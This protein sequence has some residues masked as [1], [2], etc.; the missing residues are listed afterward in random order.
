MVSS[1]R[2]APV[3]AD[4]YCEETDSCAGPSGDDQ[5]F[6]SDNSRYLQSGTGY[7][8]YP[9]SLGGCPGSQ[10]QEIDPVSVVFWGFATAARSLNHIEA[11]TRWTKRPTPKQNFESWGDCG[12]TYGERASG[13]YSR[14]HVRVRK[15]A[16]EYGSWGIT[17]LATPHH[18]DWIWW[19]PGIQDFPPC[20]HAVD[21]GG[22][23]TGEASGF[24]QGRSILISYMTTSGPG[25][26]HDDPLWVNWENTRE[27]QQCDGNLAGSDGWVAW[28]HIPNDYHSG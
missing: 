24:V 8:V 17:S 28:I 25:S 15:T 26:L 3:P 4:I 19:D 9:W 11:H 27:I 18:E 23:S 5:A 6:D 10:E 21:R 2:V 12:R 7:N 1:L 16:R 14:Y 20:W 13:S 22:V